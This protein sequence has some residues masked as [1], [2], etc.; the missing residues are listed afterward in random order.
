[1]NPI[2]EKLL[3]ATWIYRRTGYSSVYNGFGWII[4]GYKDQLWLGCVSPNIVIKQQ[5][6]HETEGDEI[7]CIEIKDLDSRFKIPVSNDFLTHVV[8]SANP[9]I[10]A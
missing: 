2:E 10:F 3:K 6:T 9:E 8:E 5:R 4:F 7:V 1:M